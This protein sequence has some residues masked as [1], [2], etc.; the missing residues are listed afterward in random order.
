VTLRS[1]TEWMETVA[2]GWNTLADTDPELIESALGWARTVSRGDHV[3][4]SR[5][6]SASSDGPYGDGHAAEKIVR[7]LCDKYGRDQGQ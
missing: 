5:E 7:I 2:M 4:L 6:E 1:E 3:S